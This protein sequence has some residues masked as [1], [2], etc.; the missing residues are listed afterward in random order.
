MLVFVCVFLCSVCYKRL[1]SSGCLL[2]C[3]LFIWAQFVLGFSAVHT[4]AMFFQ[5]HHHQQHHHIFYYG[6][7]F[8]PLNRYTNTQQKWEK[9]KRY[10]RVAVL[11]VCCCKCQWTY[12]NPMIKPLH[13]RQ[14][15]LPLCGCRF[16]ILREPNF[17]SFELI[18]YNLV[19][20]ACCPNASTCTH[21][22]IP[23]TLTP[24]LPSHPR[25]LPHP[26]HQQCQLMKKTEIISADICTL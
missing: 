1:F 3:I 9:F 12:L 16:L 22:L 24:T 18:E 21:S 13:N 14:T 4:E 20:N 17:I 15:F 2:F 23:S 6:A 8:M 19:S 7:L 10:F 11:I 25:S 5:Q 26:P